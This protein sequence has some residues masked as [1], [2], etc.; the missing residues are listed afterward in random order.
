MSLKSECLHGLCVSL[1]RAQYGKNA[2]LNFKF[3]LKIPG[4]LQKTKMGKNQG[5][6]L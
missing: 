6:W 5:H 2:V 4:L 1:S 3:G